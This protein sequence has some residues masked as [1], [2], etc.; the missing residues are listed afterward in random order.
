[1]LQLH[2]KT[3]RRICVAGFVL[4]CVV[5][6]VLVAVWCIARNMPGHVPAEAR[7][8]SRELGLD[9]SLDGLR[10][11]R[12]GVVLY[13]GLELADPE[14][15]A[16][17]LRCRLLEATR[18]HTTDQQGKRKSLLVLVAWQPELQAA[19]FDRLGQL[20]GRT[21]QRQTGRPDVDVQLTAGEVTL[22]AGE[23]SQTLTELQGSIETLPA[24]TQAQLSFRL[25]GTDMPEPMRIRIARNRQTTPPATGFELDTGGTAIP[26]SLLAMGLKALRPLGPRSRL[27]GYIWANQTPDGWDAEVTGELFD[28]DL[29]RLVTEWFPHKLSGT[30]QVMIQSARFRAGRLVMASGILT[31]GPGVISRSLINAAVGQ[32]KLVPG[33]EPPMPGGLVPYEQLALVFILDAQ[34]LTLYGRCTAT[35]PG[36]IL[37]DRNGRLLGEPASQPQPV[38]ALLQ[39]LVPRSEVQVP[40]TR[41]TDWLMRHLPVPQVVRREAAEATLPHARVRLGRTKR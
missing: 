11:L 25:A 14:T 7:R 33:M 6:T 37:A 28:V 9:V 3:R 23:N 39:T 8:L 5:P 2:D 30:G 4:L 16:T 15:D 26:C 40:A 31:A 38:V 27:R 19:G 18:K 1:M 10:H 20:L 21:L 35:A 22:R 12:P 34:G 17:V 41:Q 13:E 32:L 29:G 24:G 36:T